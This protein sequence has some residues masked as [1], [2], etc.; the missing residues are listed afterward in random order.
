[1]GKQKRSKRKG[2]RKSRDHEKGSNSQPSSTLLFRLRSPDNKL[3]YATLAACMHHIPKHRDDILSAVRDCVMDHDLECSIAAAGCIA[4]CCSDCGDDQRLLQLSSNWLVLIVGRLKECLE[5][6]QDEQKTQKPLWWE[7]TERCLKCVVV[8]I[9]NNPLAMERVIFNDS[10]RTDILAFPG[11][12]VTTSMSALQSIP[13]AACVRR[14]PVLAL[15]L[16]HS[17][18]ENNEDLLVPW[19]QLGPT[20]GATETLDLLNR[21]VMSS[22]GELVPIVAQYHAVGALLAMYNIVPEM[23]NAAAVA[24][25]VDLLVG[26]IKNWNVDANL[27]TQLKKIRKGQEDERA[28][29]L[30]EREILAEQARKKEPAKLIARRQKALKSDAADSMVED[31]PEQVTAENGVMN[32]G[33]TAEDIEEQWNDNTLPLS[34]VLEVLGNAITPQD[35]MDEQMED[36]NLVFEGLCRNP[37]VDSLMELFIKLA[38]GDEFML[39]VCGDVMAKVV[40]CIGNCIALGSNE[41]EKNQSFSMQQ[42]WERLDQAFANGSDVSVQEAIGSTQVLVLRNSDLELDDS[43][44]YRLLDRTGKTESITRDAITL[45]GQHLATSPHSESVNRKTTQQLMNLCTEGRAPPMILAEALGV[46]M[47]IYGNDDCHPH[48]FDE[49]CVLRL[50]QQATPTLKQRIE[51]ARNGAHELEIE[52]WLEVAENAAN[53]I[54]YKK[55]LC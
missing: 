46:L 50:F 22:A 24:R 36:S 35:D 45:L 5:S 43:A 42:I 11:L 55:G 52:Q 10:I 49:L 47:D 21:I 30:L 32:G 40:S 12:F 23:T 44:V 31:E 6:L 27:L 13:V 7:L 26:E 15:R 4:N 29:A 16:C 34:L 1:M 3:R 8:M 28:D 48:V 14:I 54:Q 17:T 19:V 37:V 38:S 25:C 53:F 41:S 18:W 20:S 2:N 51:L 33:P 9:E 39:T